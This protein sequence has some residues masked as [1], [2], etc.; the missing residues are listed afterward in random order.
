MMD[1]EERDEFFNR[2][3]DR[4]TAEELVEILGLST[5]DVVEQFRDYIMQFKLTEVM[6]ALDG[7]A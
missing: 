5:W 2:V 4:F 6:D 3:C 1:R 7:N